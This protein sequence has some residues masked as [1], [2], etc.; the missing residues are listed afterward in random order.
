MEVA[1]ILLEFKP[2]LEL[3]DNLN[4]TPLLAASRL[5]KT[6]I[7][8]HLLAAGADIEA[9]VDPFNTSLTTSVLV[10]NFHLAQLL[11]DKGASLGVRGREKVT[12]L[13]NAAAEDDLEAIESLSKN[14]SGVGAQDAEGRTPLMLAA[15]YR[16]AASMGILMAHGASICR[17]A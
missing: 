2:D 4:E 5:S 10:K 1:E 11:I 12:L 17:I 3:R 9:K 6:E 8:Q 15:R 16:R 14:R 7:V 13:H